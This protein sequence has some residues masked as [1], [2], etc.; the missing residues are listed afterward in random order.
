MN[1]KVWMA[2]AALLLLAGCSKVTKANYDKIKTGMQ[3]DEVVRL[4]GE[5]TDCSEAI[6]LSSCTWKSGD[7]EVTVNFIANKVTISS[8]SGLK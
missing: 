7:A 6:G 5:P 4:I 3:Y 8:A 1:K 2:V